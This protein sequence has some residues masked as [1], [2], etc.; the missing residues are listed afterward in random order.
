MRFMCY[1]IQCFFFFLLGCRL[2]IHSRYIRSY[3]N[4]SNNNN[5]HS[6]FFFK[7]CKINI[8]Q[9]RIISWCGLWRAL[10]IKNDQSWGANFCKMANQQRLT[11]LKISKPQSDHFGLSCEFYVELGNFNEN[12]IERI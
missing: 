10:S 3:S 5:N 4:N 11:V 6:L 12:R 1:T 7:H 2:F 9:I 8:E